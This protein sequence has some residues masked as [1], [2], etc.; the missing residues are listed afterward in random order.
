MALKFQKLEEDYLT[1]LGEFNTIRCKLECKTDSLL[2]LSHELEQCRSER[3]QYKLM[4]EQ[5]RE[6]YS[7]LKR[8]V[9]GWGP[10]LL[11][12]YD[13]GGLKCER[14]KSLVQLLCELKDQNRSL[15]AQTEE[16]KQRLNESQGDVKILR[17]ELG[18]QHMSECESLK[19]IPFSEK[20]TAVKL[21][22]NQKLKCLQLTRDLQAVLDEKEELVTARDAYRHK[23]ER[24]NKQLN[25]MLR[26]NEKTHVDIDGI[27]ME[28]RFLQERI[29]Q[30]QEEKSM[31]ASSLAKCRALLEKKRTK[32]GMSSFTT[33]LAISA[34][35]VE[36]L[37]QNKSFLDLSNKSSTTEFRNIVITLLEALSDKS[38]ALSHQKKANK[39]LGNRISELEEKIKSMEISSLWRLPDPSQF[40]CLFNESEE[41]GDNSPQA[42][43]LL[44]AENDKKEQEEDAKSEEPSSEIS[45]DA[46]THS[47]FSDLD[48]LPTK[49]YSAKSI[50]SEHRGSLSSCSHYSDSKLDSEPPSPFHNDI[51]TLNSDSEIMSKKSTH[52]SGDANH[53]DLDQRRLSELEIDD[54][55]PKLQK[56]IIAALV[57]MEDEEEI[58]ARTPEHSQNSPITKHERC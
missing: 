41:A 24:L 6:R 18:K 54:L 53:I 29:K 33:G 57:E 40:P 20:E 30:V 16:L 32:G 50:E 8:R 38:I 27:L 39:I 42:S 7:A 14:E 46:R 34:K 56:L 47:G 13:V 45:N 10:S 58:R 44:L 37:L 28:N 49:D 36:H 15:K 2:I 51:Q 26:G 52:H 22:E 5:L 4:A 17:D 21:L 9:E 25:Y 35:Q 31:T 3:D 48:I 1:L 23:F 43:I 11:G 55:P 12:V 19:H